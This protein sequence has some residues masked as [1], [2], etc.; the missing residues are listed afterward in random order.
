M[1]LEKGTRLKRK[2]HDFGEVEILSLDRNYVTIVDANG[3]RH[4]VARSKIEDFF[5]ILAK[6]DVV[7]VNEHQN[8]DDPNRHNISGSMNFP[9]RAA[10]ASKKK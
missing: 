8:Y 4:I 2:F 5:E 1:I 9:D 6:D 10:L 7:S 3:I